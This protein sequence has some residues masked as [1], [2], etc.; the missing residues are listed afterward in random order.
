MNSNGEFR[1]IVRLIN[2]PKIKS[3]SITIEAD[4]QDELPV[5]SDVDD[6]IKEPVRVATDNEG[7]N[8]AREY[9]YFWEGNRLGIV[10]KDI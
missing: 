9:A 8:R 10:E 7:D 1:S 4:D 6:P 5:V 2:K 3:T